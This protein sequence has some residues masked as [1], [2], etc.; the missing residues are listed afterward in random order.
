MFKI[1]DS[2]FL[3]IIIIS[4]EVM[5]ISNTLLNKR[6]GPRNKSELFTIGRDTV[7]HGRDPWKALQNIM[8]KTLQKC[9]GKKL[10]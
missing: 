5:R 7:E 10:D 8:D 2:K 3:F 4:T 6:Y 9:T 1:I